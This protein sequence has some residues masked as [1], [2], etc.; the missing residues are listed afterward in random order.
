MKLAVKERQDGRKHHAH[1]LTEID[2][3]AGLPPQT[4]PDAGA[5]GAVESMAGSRV[6]VRALLE[7]VSSADFD[8]ARFQLDGSACFVRRSATSHAGRLSTLSTLSTRA[9]GR[10]ALRC[11]HGSLTLLTH[12]RVSLPP[13]HASP[14]VGLDPGEAT[15]YAEADA[16][17]VALVA[18]DACPFWEAA[19][20]LTLAARAG[21]VALVV[22]EDARGLPLYNRHRGLPREARGRAARSVGRVDVQTDLLVQLCESLGLP[23]EAVRVCALRHSFAD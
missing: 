17:T 21:R 3:P 23:D 6:P 13:P 8:V 14:V 7:G 1:E 12:A 16:R 19:Q 18:V 10:R 5:T 22:V 11:P 4:S 9:R 15:G 20:R 2:E